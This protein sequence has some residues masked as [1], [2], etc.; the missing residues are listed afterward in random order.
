MQQ[1]SEILKQEAPLTLRGQ[2]GRCKNIKGVVVL[3]GLGE[4][5]LHAKIEFASISRCTNIKG[6][7]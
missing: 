7:P 4:P 3:W 5:Q 1:Q 6:K 2:R